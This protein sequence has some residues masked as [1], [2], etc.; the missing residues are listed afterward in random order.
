MVRTKLIGPKCSRCCMVTSVW[1][2][3]MFLLMG[4]AYKLHSPAL[5]DDVNI[6]A[7]RIADKDYVYSM[8]DETGT[9]CFI[10][11]GVYVAVFFFSLWQFRVN[12]TLQAY[13]IR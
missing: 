2:V 7:T 6:N 12:Q 3:V 1:G 11:A 4:G 8:Y 13:T 9:N 10:V 5:Y